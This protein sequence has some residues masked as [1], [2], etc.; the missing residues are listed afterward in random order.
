MKKYSYILLFIIANLLFANSRVAFLRPGAFMRASNHEPYNANKLFSIGIGSEITSIGDITSHS[1]SFAFNKTNTNGSSWGLSYTVLPYTGIDP[2]VANSEISYEIGAHFQSN[3]YSTGKTNVTAG[4]HD[5]LLSD[6]EMIALKDLS[7]FI[8]FSN[9][10]SINKYSLESLVG[11]GSGRMAFDPHTERESSSS[12]GVYAALKLNTPLLSS[13]GGVDF[14]TEFLHGGL[15][16]GLTIP[17]TNEYNFS[18]GITHVENLSDFASQSAGDDAL[19]LQKDSPAI[20]L[21]LGIDLPRVNTN[22]V[23]KVA[24]EYPILFIN[25]KVDSSLFN[26]GEYIYFLQDSLA[27]LQQTIN[28]VSGENIALTLENQSFQDSLNSLILESNINISKHNKAMRHLSTSLRFYYQGNFQQ[29][30]QEVEK[31]IALQ[32]NTAV[33]YARKGSI[34]YKLNQLDRAT[35]NWNIALKLDPEYTEVRDMLNALK[36]NKLRPLTTN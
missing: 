16:L 1:S 2:A 13:W 17:F 33:A 11:F 12:L 18:I 29:A 25:G 26:A 7:V 15:N 36:E 4:I 32:P 14:V 27:L 30:L 20:C 35:L 9:S 34:Y 28:T 5:F 3:L 19:E 21:G 23:R 10:V 8:N 22:K 24:Q 6:D 31:A